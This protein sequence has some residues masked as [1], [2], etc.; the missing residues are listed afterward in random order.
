MA[1]AGIGNPAGAIQIDGF[2][3][4]NF[5][6]TAR[7]NISGGAFV[8][9]SGTGTGS[10]AWS[11]GSVLVATDA[12]GGNF[13]GIAL[14]SALSGT[15]VPVALQGIFLLTANG[16]VLASNG[17]NCDGNNSVLP[18]GSETLTNFTTTKQIGR[19]LTNGTSGGFCA[20]FVRG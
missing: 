16:T 8:F 17:V 6:A 19:A 10:V 5:T 18:A 2:D 12:S 15:V 11:I 4:I 13:T 7:S 3:P 9:A 1:A 20:V 14:Q